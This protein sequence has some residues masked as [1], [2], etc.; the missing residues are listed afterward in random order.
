M[1]PVEETESA[2]S[3]AASAQTAA[4]APPAGPALSQAT[5]PAAPAESAGAAAAGAAPAAS[6]APAAAPQQLTIEGTLTATPD[7]AAAHALVYLVDA[8]IVPTRGMKVTVDQKSMQFI[9]YTAAIAAGGTVTF[10]N[11]DPFP[12]NV[13]STGP[14]KFNIGMLNQNQRHAVTLKEPGEYPLLCNVHPGML[15]HVYVAP[16]SYFAISD[17][18]GKYAIKDVPEGT[19]RIAAWAGKFKGDEQTVKLQGANATVDFALHK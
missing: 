7:R 10:V 5:A 18:H 1:A 12:H 13:F 15:G 14:Q 17:A 11:S 16:S 3:S 6:A 2:P 9:P 4:A 19:Y 8:P